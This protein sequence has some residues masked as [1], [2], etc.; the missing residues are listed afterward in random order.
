M[1]SLFS[2]I[3]INTFSDLKSKEDDNILDMNDVCF[4]CAK[5]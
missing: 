3:I 1:I 2:G 5:N 4:I